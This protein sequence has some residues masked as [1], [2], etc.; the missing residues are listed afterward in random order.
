MDRGTPTVAVLPC[1]LR[2]CGAPQA[3]FPAPFHNL[4]IYIFIFIYRSECLQMKEQFSSTCVREREIGR[5]SGERE[6]FIGFIPLRAEQG[7]INFTPFIL[8]LP[9]AK[10]KKLNFPYGWGSVACD[11]FVPNYL[12]NPWSDWAKFFFTKTKENGYLRI[13]ILNFR[14]QDPRVKALG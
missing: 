3:N 1:G 7:G 8:S 11:E 9:Y 10:K 14:G 13:L 4:F 5:E 2:T 6:S 12:L